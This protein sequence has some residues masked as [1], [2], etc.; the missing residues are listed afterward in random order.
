MNLQWLGVEAFCPQLRKF[1]ITHSRKETVISPLFPGY[2]FSKFD[3]NTEFCR[4]NY[5]TGVD[6]VV[7]FGSVVARVDAE[8]IALIKARIQ[9]GYVHLRSPSFKA[10]QEARINEGPFLGLEAVFEEDLSGVQRVAL[11]LKT[12]SYQ[13]R[14]ITDREQVLNL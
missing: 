2:L 4:V 1:K 9:N 3:Q 6:N 13:A 7:K 14:L 11:L 12:V 5:A 10:G 8:T